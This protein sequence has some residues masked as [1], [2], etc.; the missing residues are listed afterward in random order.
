MRNIIEKT[1]TMNKK[2]VCGQLFRGLNGSW[3]K[4]INHGKSNR[5]SGIQETG[6]Y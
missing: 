4:G 1:Q 6:K 5:I 2:T 3:D